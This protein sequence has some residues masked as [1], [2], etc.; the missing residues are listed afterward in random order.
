MSRLRG[1]QQKPAMTVSQALQSQKTALTF[2]QALQSQKIPRQDAEWLLQHITG[3][4]RA[5]FLLYPHRELTATQEAAFCEG[6]ARLQQNEP[7]QYILGAWEFMGLPILCGPEALVPRGDTEL[8][9]QLATDFLHENFHGGDALDLCTGTGCV[10]IALAHALPHAT[11]HAVDISPGAL[12]LA[13]KNAA[14]NSVAVT[15][16]EGDLFAPLG[17]ATFDCITA[18]PPYI[19]SGEMAS[20]PANVQQEP[21]LALD[22]GPGGLDFYH[23]LAAHLPLYLRP[24]GAAFLEIGAP[25]AADVVDILRPYFPHPVVHQDLNGRD[26]VVAIK[27]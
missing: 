18:N 23:R 24:G 13:Q 3:Q 8:L 14:L 4:T 27:K 21:A 5:D 10:A 7:L 12:A 11:V 9:A 25:Q 19:P 16:H 26:R 22:G 1:G 15:F 2:S 6:L 17:A 20:L